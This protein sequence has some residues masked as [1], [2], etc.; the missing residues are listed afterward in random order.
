MKTINDFKNISSA[1]HNPF[2]HPTEIHKDEQAV[3]IEIY[4][5]E[6]DTIQFYITDQKWITRMSKDDKF[7]VI[8]YQTNPNS[9][10]ILVVKGKMIAGIQFPPKKKC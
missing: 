3:E 7:E 4:P 9:D 1:H 6:P 8:E 5:T 2:Q 10:K